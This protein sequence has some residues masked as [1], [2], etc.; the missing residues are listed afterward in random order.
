MVSVVKSGIRRNSD[1]SFSD[2]LS[3]PSISIASDLKAD[4]KIEPD[5]PSDPTASTPVS[6]VV[7]GSLDQ[8]PQLLDTTNSATQRMSICSVDAANAV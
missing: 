3:I 1:V 6:S 2:Q 8:L 4:F 7:G 5:S